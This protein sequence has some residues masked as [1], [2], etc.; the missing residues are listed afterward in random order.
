MSGGYSIRI[1]NGQW[2]RIVPIIVNDEE[3]WTD[4][5]RTVVGASPNEVGDNLVARARNH[6]WM[7]ELA[8]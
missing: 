8:A 7:W 5:E 4:E 6:A 2:R 3:C 1:D